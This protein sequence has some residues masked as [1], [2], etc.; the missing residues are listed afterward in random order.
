[1][2]SRIGETRR[3]RSQ[4]SIARLMVFIAALALALAIVRE[5]VLSLAGE[6]EISVLGAFGILVLGGLLIAGIYGAAYLLLVMIPRVM[7]IIILW[8]IPSLRA[9]KEDPL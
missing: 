9:N 6:Q 4:R 2:S 1:M 3:R 7:L 5:T 8:L